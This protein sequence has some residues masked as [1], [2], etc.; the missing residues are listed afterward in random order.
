MFRLSSN[1]PISLIGVS[2]SGL[3]CFALHERAAVPAYMRAP[4]FVWRGTI[5]FRNIW[6][7]TSSIEA[8]QWEIQLALQIRITRRQQ[9]SQRQGAAK[10]CRAAYRRPWR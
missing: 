4:I 1:L 8:C 7:S 9:T 5:A 2:S 3:L 6:S 10:G